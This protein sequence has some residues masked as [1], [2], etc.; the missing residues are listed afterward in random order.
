MQEQENRYY[1]QTG[2][3][4]TCRSYD[5][6]VRMFA[7]DS[8]TL[9][10]KSILDVAAGASSFAAEASAKGSSVTAADPLYRMTPGQ[11]AEQGAKEIETSTAKLAGLKDR[12][13]WE[14]YGSLERHRARRERSLERFVQDYGSLKP[15]V[16]YVDAAL[17]N[18]PFDDDTFDL[19][20]CSHFLFLYEEQFDYAFHAAAVRELL[21]LTRPGGEL[22]LYPI[23]GFRTERYGQLDRL[24]LER[25]KRK[26]SWCRHRSR[27]CR[28]RTNVSF[29]KNLTTLVMYKELWIDLFYG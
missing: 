16:R 17:P 19:T 11:I 23:V 8:D 1:R 28:I 3:A 27:S 21:R 22:R 4:M 6:Y 26:A 5:E 20:L 9:P 13:L 12:Y 15:A 29:F 7:L 24:R 2:V 10:G 14:Y 25:P 18:L